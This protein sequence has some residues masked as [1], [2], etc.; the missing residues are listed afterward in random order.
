[1]DTE[2]NDHRESLGGGRHDQLWT[3]D[4][5]VVFRFAQSPKLQMRSGLGFNWLSD[6]IG[7]EE[8]FNFT[9]SGD[10]FPADP[11]IMSGEIDWGTLGSAGL[12]H[13][14]ATVGVHYHRCEVYTGYD[15]LDIGD[16]Q[17]DGLV[18]GLRVWY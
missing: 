3:G 17:I 1:L 15:Y 5:N 16:T 2:A 11:W 6:R 7:G 10:F 18:A 12:F 9:Y 13:G 4:C 14:R 8:G